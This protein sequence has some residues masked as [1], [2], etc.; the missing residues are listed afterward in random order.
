[1][2]DSPHILHVWDIAGI[3]AFLAHR[4]NQDCIHRRVQDPFHQTGMYSESYLVGHGME[5]RVRMG[6]AKY[7]MLRVAMRARHADMLHVHGGHEMAG[8]VSGQSN[9][10]YILHYHGSDVR[11]T[12]P[13]RRRDAERGAAKVL[14]STEDLLDETY[15]VEP[16]WLSN[17][18]DTDRFKP[19]ASP[20]NN[21]GLVIIRDDQSS[22]HTMER[23]NELGHSGIDWT[24]N[25]RDR[26]PLPYEDMPH[27]LSTYEYFADIKWNAHR[28]EWYPVISKTTLESLAVGLKVILHDGTIIKGLPE[29][30][31]PE[32]VTERLKAIYREALE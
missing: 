24:V 10:P 23:L 30:H 28:T 3:G 31:R 9:K 18:I 5:R 15:A 25:S 26:H 8:A 17:P 1:M 13:E 12:P 6:G 16:E 32:R 20:H 11:L 22:G 29:R 27:T 21:R 19:H 4:M 2:T 7:F 14:V